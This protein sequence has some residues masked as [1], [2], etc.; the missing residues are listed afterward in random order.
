MCG[1]V[2]FIDSVAR[3]DTIADMLRVV[4][5]RGPDDQG[6]YIDDAH[7][8]VVHLGHARLSI[9]DLSPL[10]HQPLISE[11]EDY[12][13]TYNGEVYNFNAIREKLATLGYNFI[14]TSDTE[15]ILNAFIEWGIEAVER[16]IGMFAFAIY[17]KSDR[18]LTLVRDRAGVKPLYYF[19]DENHFMFASE[20]K[21]LMRHPDYSKHINKEI[22][23]FYFQFGY[24]PAPHA[25]FTDTY[26][27][28]P[29]HYMV[30]DVDTFDYEIKKYWD[31]TDFYLRE[32]TTKS[33]NEIIGDI[34]SLLID[35]CQL[36]MVSD[37]P[38]GIFLSG[39]YDSS[40]VT[41]L[42]Q[43]TS[44]EQLSTFTIGFEEKE[45]DE[46]VH[47][48]GIADYLGTKHTEHYFSEKEMLDLID[49]LP[50]Y[51]DEPFADASALPTIL[52]SQLARHDVTVA[53]S[54]DG[55]DE[56]F[57][58]YSKYF[59]M[60]K[61]EKLNA[62]KLLLLRAAVKCLSVDTVKMI[63]SM[64][65]AAKRQSNIE[66]KFLK[67]KHAIE[68]AGSAERFIEA[69]SMVSPEILKL[70]L[71]IGK[72]HLFENTNFSDMERLKNADVADMMMAIDYKTF[73]VDDVLTKVDRA[74]MSV[75]LEGREP[76]LDHRIVEYLATVPAEL[77]YKNGDGKY[78]L[79]Q[80]LYKYLP[81]DL[82]DKP[83]SGFTIPLKK[84]LSTDLKALVLECLA[85]P[86]LVEDGI[87]D[88][89]NLLSLK[90]QVE[91][92]EIKHTSLIWTIVSY[93][94]WREKW[95]KESY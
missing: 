90:Q 7:D 4:E 79:R 51:Y 45:Y 74:T 67:F 33:E 76:L 85:N 64:L 91:E 22:L 66:E 15:V 35:A 6:V 50:W 31:V 82:V 88:Y 73:M 8:K 3:S 84:W 2:G 5:H 87:I 24:I 34:H 36:R 75:S 81:R 52:V 54:A 60:E 23:P 59:A 13:I 27:L 14:S 58:G 95:V 69:S 53:L 38:V 63:N 47:A 39:G 43:S 65:P 78:L 29:G 46:A 71:K 83:K 32:K 16:F 44:Q 25:I 57:F 68:C 48:R 30:L 17:S 20:I 92:G 10:G 26:K 62:M 49:K 9:Q 80:I 41:A 77:K 37:V 86:V 42:L 72:Y 61:V 55:G 40:L 12:I 94:M 21:S 1:I 19:L 18:Q 28:L 11:N 89:I 56:A 93:V 70:F